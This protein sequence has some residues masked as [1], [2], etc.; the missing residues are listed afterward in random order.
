MLLSLFMY[1]STNANAGN[2]ITL[3]IFKSMKISKRKKTFRVLLVSST[4]C[5]SLNIKCQLRHSSR[6]V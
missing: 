5:H 4:R 6:C 1:R 3:H 2:Q